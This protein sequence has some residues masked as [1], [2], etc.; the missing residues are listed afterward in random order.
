MT[1]SA[2]ALLPTNDAA[3]CARSRPS[4]LR[5]QALFDAALELVSEVGY[6]RLSMDGLA[7]RAGVSKA[8]IYRH[9]TGKADVVVDA[10][11][12]RACHATPV[13]D[14]GSLR[15]DLLA[16][17]GMLCEAVAREEGALLVGLLRAM[18]TDPVLAELLQTQILEG[19]AELFGVLVARGI[20]RGEL[21]GTVDIPTV[22]EVLTS[23][24]FF[25]LLMATG[26]LDDEF[27]VK[28]VDHVLLPV[29]MS[30]PGGPVQYQQLSAN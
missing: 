11:R 25:R 2:S 17:L 3:D 5:V 15:A 10:M 28:F 20:V 12:T 27:C 4:E 9:W 1:L 14:Q 23:V 6:D 26:E 8:T 29:V 30:G 21:E 16:Q 22:L 24:V 18:Q 7:E 13:E 19:K